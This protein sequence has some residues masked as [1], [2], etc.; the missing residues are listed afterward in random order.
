MLLGD[1][2]YANVND[3]ISTKIWHPSIGIQIANIED[4]PGGGA[5]I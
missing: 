2:N 1:G 4:L 3:D 5:C